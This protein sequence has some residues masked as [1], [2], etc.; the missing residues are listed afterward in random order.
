MFTGIVE[1][2][3]TVRALRRYGDVWR[4][5]IAAAAVCEGTAAGDSIA[6]DGVC[7]TAVSVA[8]DGFEAEISPETRSRSTLE[9][10]GPGA[11]V[12]LERAL[13]LGTRLGGHLVQGHV[14]ARGR[15]AS[16]QNRGPA[17][18]LVIRFP[19]EGRKYL[20]LKGAVAVD[21][22]SLTVAAL[23]A[24]TFAAAVIPHTLAHTTLLGKKAGDEVNLEYDVIAKYVESL[25]AYGKTDAGAVTMD[26]LREKG[27]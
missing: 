17:A 12:N 26:F 4:M 18:E 2:T 27:F 14:D 5:A 19:A 20:A 8:E 11:V 25:L 1:E 7:L 23:E 22:I 15:I 3:G 24:E 10:A 6:V 13:A 9:H 16:L 21:G